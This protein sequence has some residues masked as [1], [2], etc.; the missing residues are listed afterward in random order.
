MA[1]V[2]RWYKTEKLP[3]GGSRR[4]KSAEYGIGKR[5]QVRYVDDQGK[6]T[7]KNFAREAPAKRFDAQTQA[8][9]DNDE[10]V[11]P[12]KSK[13]RFE[14]YAS[15]WLE[16]RTCDDNT[17]EGY[18]RVLRLHVL[19]VLGKHSLITLAKTPSLV[20]KWISECKGAPSTLSRYRGIVSSIFE[21]AIDDGYISKNPCKAKSITIPSQP[22]TNV[23]PLTNEQALQLAEVFGSFVIVGVGTGLRQSEILALS[24]SDIDERT[25]VVRVRRQLRQVKGG[26]V[27]ALPKHKRT[28]EV[29]L[30]ESV[31]LAIKAIA[32]ANVPREVTLPWNILGGRPT[33]VKILFPYKDGPYYRRT[34]NALWKT[35]L[36]KVGLPL[37]REYGTHV[38]RH[39][40]ASRLLSG[41]VD[42]RSLSQYLGHSDPGFTLRTYTHLMPGN[43][44]KARSVIDSAFKIRAISGQ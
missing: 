3:D 1:V 15:L 2:D 40:Y 32:H 39:T 27:F 37:T 4:V 28:R 34:F 33:T 9:L 41:G 10:Y 38:C 43:E 25:G 29:P 5:W 6:S 19:P 16:S 14:S 13:T 36:R 12:N 7:K 35:A 20:Q 30:P 44:Q 26:I 42:I 22:K 17:K 23:V 31:L 24:E 11:D 21:T 18:E 8:A